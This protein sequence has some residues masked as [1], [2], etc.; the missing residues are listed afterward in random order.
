MVGRKVPM[1]VNYV[2]LGDY[3]I[4]L[5][6][7]MIVLS[8]KE[9]NDIIQHFTIARED[10]IIV[11]NNV[12]LELEMSEYEEIVSSLHGLLRDAEEENLKLENL[13]L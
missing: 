13:L 6:N 1:T 2:G 12:K 7:K 4:Y 11:P 3:K 10:N 8:E 5:D 9:I